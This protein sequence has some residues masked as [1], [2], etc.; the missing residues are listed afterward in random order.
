MGFFYGANC[1][2]FGLSTFHADAVPTFFQSL[3][4]AVVIIVGNPLLIRLFRARLE[5]KRLFIAQASSFAFEAARCSV[6]SDRALVRSM[7]VRMMKDLGHVEKD[8]VPAAAVNAFDRFVRA[9]F[10]P[11]VKSFFKGEVLRYKDM[12]LVNLAL[13]SVLVDMDVVYC[14]K[15]VRFIYSRVVF[16]C[17]NALIEEPIR[18]WIAQVTCGNRMLGGGPVTVSCCYFGAVFLA[19][20]ILQVEVVVHRPFF[21]HTTEI[22]DIALFVWP[23][24]YMCA[25][26]GVYHTVQWSPACLEEKYVVP[27]S[28]LDELKVETC[29]NPGGAGGATLRDDNVFSI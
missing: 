23:M 4:L 22:S 20:V 2:Y 7:L 19:V 21:R 8:E 10:P 1:V 25:H 3:L 13:A 24:I 15:G 17:W 29:Q 6:E 9:L 12:V 27:S 16:N 18:Y 28:S 11:E 26:F 5:M 14:D